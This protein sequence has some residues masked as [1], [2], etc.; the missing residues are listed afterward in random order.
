MTKMPPTWAEWFGKRTDHCLVSL[1]TSDLNVKIRNHLPIIDM[2]K[3]LFHK[4]QAQ[5][6]VDFHK[7]LVCSPSIQ[8]N[9]QRHQSRAL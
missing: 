8:Q 6:K 9:R 3:I 7:Q 2:T 4:K 5:M 1:C